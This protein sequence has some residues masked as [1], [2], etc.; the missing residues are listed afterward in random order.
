MN[1]SKG[2]DCNI[3][4]FFL[5]TIII[6]KVDMVAA[7]LMNISLFMDEHTHTHVSMRIYFLPVFS[8]FRKIICVYC[9]KI[10]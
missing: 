1:A 8:S 2:D 9:T 6:V 7:R 3:R 10:G 4:G 5:A